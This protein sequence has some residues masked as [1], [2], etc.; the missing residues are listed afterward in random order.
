MTEA[1]W[2]ACTDSAKMLRQSR[3]FLEQWV[4]R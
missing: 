3:R 2:L 1:E 4:T